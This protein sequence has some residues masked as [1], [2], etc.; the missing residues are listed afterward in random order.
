M[1]SLLKSIISIFKKDKKLN[2]FESSA[3]YWENRYLSKGNSGSGSYGRLAGF[4][5]KIIND[6]VLDNNIKEVIEFGCGDGNQL[7]LSNYP[8]YIGFDV[9]NKSIDI[10]REKFSND[11][12]KI[13]LNIKDFRNQKADLVLSLDVIYHLVEDDVFKNYMFDLF[14][15]STKYVIIYSSNHD[16]YKTEHVKH[17]I[18]TDW[19]NENIKDFK[20]KD[21]IPN[22][23]PYQEG[24]PETSYADF[25][26]YEKF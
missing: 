5:S 6:F 3:K 4:K 13:F 14:K 26:I 18:F 17:R 12:G 21:I 15:A 22:D 10:C 25:Y 19:I 9:S 1:N 8:S 7:K 2:T 16:E 20:I 11:K 24:V 23:Y